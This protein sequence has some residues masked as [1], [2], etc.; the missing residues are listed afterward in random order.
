M[1][2]DKIPAD[3]L[4]LIYYNF[5]HRH[6]PTNSSLIRR[7]SHCCCSRRKKFH[8]SVIK[9][10][11]KFSS[12]GIAAGLFGREMNKWI[13][14]LH[15]FSLKCVQSSSVFIVNFSKFIMQ[16]IKLENFSPSSSCEFFLVWP[17]QLFFKAMR[18]IS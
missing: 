5:N 9:T 6:F 14:K 16:K 3:S 10:E 8:V 12:T 15:F 18:F 13:L 4:N 17:S 1:F 7:K 2:L 11:K